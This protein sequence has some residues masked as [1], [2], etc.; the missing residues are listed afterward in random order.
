MERKETPSADRTSEVAP[1]I[2]VGAT[3][4]KEI[5]GFGSR[6]C[7]GKKNPNEIVF[8]SIPVQVR[9]FETNPTYHI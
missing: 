1:L 8:G 4:R 2:S 7:Y 5:A 3:Y 9:Y 6:Y